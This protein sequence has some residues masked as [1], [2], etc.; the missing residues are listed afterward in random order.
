MGTKAGVPD[1]L[2]LSHGRL[3]GLELKAGYGK[4]STTQV[5]THSAMREAGAVIGVA[6]DIDQALNL[7]SVGRAAMTARERLANRRASETF[8]LTANGLSYR[9][10]VSRF[11][12]GRIAEIFLS[13]HKTGS[14]ADTA[15]KDSAVVCSIALQFGVPLETIRR[16]LMRDSRGRPNGPLGIA[17]DLLA[18][19]GF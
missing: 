3:Y 11:D 2:I 1:L 4:P 13:N 9:A 7:L 15:A 6:S 5:E 17:L 18:N 12:D 19:I 16:A 8:N 14:H 10:T